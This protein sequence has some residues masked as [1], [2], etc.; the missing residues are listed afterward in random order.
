MTAQTIMVLKQKQGE[1]QV[2]KCP[3]F[4]LFFRQKYR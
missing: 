2:K 3:I 4:A 1:Y